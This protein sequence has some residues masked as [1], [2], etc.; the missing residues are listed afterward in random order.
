MFCRCYCICICLF[1][2]NLRPR[3][4]HI[5]PQLFHDFSFINWHNCLFGNSPFWLLGYLTARLL[6]HLAS[7]AFVEVQC[8]FFTTNIKK[9]EINSFT[10]WANVG[11]VGLQLNT[12]NCNYKIK[13]NHQQ[14]QQLH[15][16]WCVSQRMHCAKRAKTPFEFV[17][18]FNRRNRLV[19]NQR[20]LS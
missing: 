16:K 2:C 9:I 4:F 20:A 13:R 14:Q 10:V 19:I 11:L 12:Q 18:N 8:V 1:A 7:I 6:S 5:V 17:P 15:V 3:I